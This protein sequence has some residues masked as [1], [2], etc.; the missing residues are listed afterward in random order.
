MRQRLVRV[1]D[2]L[3][4]FAADQRETACL[5]F[6]HLQPA[7]PTTVG[8]R[9]CLWAYDLVL[10]LQDVEYRLGTLDG[11][12]HERDHWHAGQLPGLV[13]R[14]DHDKVRQL[15][16]LVASKMG[17]EKTYA[18]TG[19]TYSRKVDAQV[20][21]AL[22]GLA[23]IGS[24]D[25]HRRA[26]PGA[27]QGARRTVREAANRLVG[28]GLQAQPDALRTHLLAGAIRHE[29]AIQPGPDAGHAVDGAYAGRQRQPPAGAS[30]GLS[31][32]GRGADAVTAT[33]ARA[34]WSIPRCI[35]R[36]LREELPFMATENI[37]MAAVAAGGDRQALHERIRQHSQAAAA[38][39]KELG[40]E[41]DL[42]QRLRGDEAF[43]AVD[44]DKTLEPS[45][46][47]GRAPQQVTEFLAEVITPVRERYRDLLEGDGADVRV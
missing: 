20:L 35:A 16:R 43:Q 9:A 11:P 18:V 7:Q 44:F 15:E 3:G 28:H 26:D 31:G 25:R 41:N 6:T 36:H 39:V 24:Q 21:D 38:T 22:S 10:D 30:A 27:S 13:W 47:V 8:K 17:F 23:Q 42:L 37:L 19:Q 12:Q 45:Q 5:G 29:P 2:A 14:V 4:R 33:S 34:W 46:F 32:R 1:I 40:G